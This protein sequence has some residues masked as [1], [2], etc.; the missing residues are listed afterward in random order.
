M[1]LP[2]TR[3]EMSKRSLFRMPRFPLSNKKMKVSGMKKKVRMKS[4]VTN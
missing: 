2:R 1:I 4:I 3:V